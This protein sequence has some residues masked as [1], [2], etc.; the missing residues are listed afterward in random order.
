MNKYQILKVIGDGTYGKVYQGI[1]KETNEKVAIKKL[2]NKMSSWEDCILQNEVRFLR[3]LNNENIVKLFE[4]IR[5]QNNDVSYIFEYCDCNFF[6]LYSI[7][8]GIIHNEN[9]ICFTVTLIVLLFLYGSSLSVLINLSYNI[10]RT[11][12]KTINTKIE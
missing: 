5:E 10:V 8:S 3:K 11:L 2:K 12:T 6:E 9:P 7:Y 1:N 4:V